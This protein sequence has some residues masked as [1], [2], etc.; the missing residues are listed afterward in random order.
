MLKYIIIL[1]IL[2]VTFG[3]A[4]INNEN[5]SNNN[6]I[7]YHNNEESNKYH[8]KVYHYILKNWGDSLDGIDVD[9]DPNIRCEWTYSDHIKNLGNKVSHATDANYF[10]MHIHHKSIHNKHHLIKNN[11]SILDNITNLFS[12]NIINDIKNDTKEYKNIDATVLT[13]GVYNIHSLWQSTRR[14]FPDTCNFRTN[15]T[16]AESEESSVRFKNSL[17][18]SSFK[19]F[20]GSSTTH[21]T[22]SIQRVY[23]HAHLNQTIKINE[24]F[25]NFTSL[26]K[27][28][29]YVAS[30]CHKRDS[31]NSN[32]DNI[33]QQLR[34][35]DIR[36]DGLG[37]CMRS[38]IG[39]EG[40]SLQHTHDSRYN[41]ILK[42]GT[43]GKFMFNMAFENSIEPGYVTEKPYDAL[44]GGSVPVY[45]G[46]SEHLK[47]LL[48]HP[49]AAI[50]VSD[51]NDNIKLLS[52]YLKYLMTNE[53]AYEE[54]R[55]WKNNFNYY[56]YISDKPLL[57]K[58][59]FCN[60][61][62]WAVHTAKY[63]ESLVH[64]SYDHCQTKPGSLNLPIDLEGKAIRGSGKQVFLYK[65]KVI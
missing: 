46:D 17:F 12:D 41:Q 61:C 7:E 20:D 5:E 34:D 53:T 14:H 21:P 30:D 19:Y 64:K 22:S 18:D 47:K 6:N 56:T 48:P 9:C 49:K 35:N 37:K 57:K 44:H 39:P 32:R 54:H 60:I 31:A 10:P 43:I 58:S 13:V 65:N 4:E 29:S 63:N 33:V 11:I 15:I 51:Y 8:I 2:I 27:G 38:P 1:I 45:L 62:K 55:E 16:L 3:N 50:F 59:W 25:V 23:H 40:I 26:I 42:I 36:V 28:G 52:D 24:N